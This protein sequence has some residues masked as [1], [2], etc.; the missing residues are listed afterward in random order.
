VKIPARTQRTLNS[1][2]KAS[3]ISK[4]IDLTTQRNSST[5]HISV[6]CD[7]DENQFQSVP[8]NTMI[9]PIQL[10]NEMPV[11]SSKQLENDEQSE[12][13]EARSLFEI[14]SNYNAES[15]SS[16]VK[17]EIAAA[18]LSLLYSSGLTKKD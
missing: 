16:L 12:Y 1:L 8:D 4:M 13:D 17:E 5:S 9:D 2:F 18:Y 14:M 7:S 3:G 11:D 10:I 15:Q 6:D